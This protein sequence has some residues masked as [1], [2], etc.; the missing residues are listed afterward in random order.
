MLLNLLSFSGVIAAFLAG[1]MFPRKAGWAVVVFAPVLGP[2]TFTPVPAESLPLTTYR[3]AFCVAMGMTLRRVSTIATVRALLRN[4]LVKLVAVFTLYVA[5]WSLQDRFAN[6]LFTYIPNAITPFLLCFILIRSEEDLIRLVKIF[7]WQAAVISLFII[8]EFCTD[9]SLSEALLR[10]VPGHDVSSIVSKK[11]EIITRAGM[12]RP[13][14]IDG[15]PVFTAYRLTF[16]F[17]LTLWYGY[18]KKPLRWVP[19]VITL[20]GLFLLQTR[21]TYVAVCAGLAFIIMEL[22]LLKGVSI[23]KKIKKGAKLGLLMAGVLIV[24]TVFYP[25]IIN[26]TNAYMEKI[27]IITEETN[28]DLSITIK[29]DRIPVAFGHF[30]NRPIMGYGSPEHVL[31]AVMKGQ[32]L[33]APM[34]YLLSGGMVLFFIYIS[35]LFYMPYSLYKMSKGKLLSVDRRR[36]LAFASAAFLAGVLVVFSNWAEKHFMIMFMLYISICKVY[37]FRLG[38]QKSAKSGHVN[39]IIVPK[40]SGIID[41]P[42]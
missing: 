17:L 2:A 21:A 13:A 39:R 7:V 5:L 32:D 1:Y 19:F 9:F 36:F 33:P 31:G 12:Y 11:H 34:I 41:A 22:V 16:L 37:T 3:I 10:T 6:V 14:G 30:M 24:I 18:G 42:V 35:I 28:W 26:K 38:W 4:P 25:E 15:H 20:A 8:V 27:W 23:V 40:T 29:L